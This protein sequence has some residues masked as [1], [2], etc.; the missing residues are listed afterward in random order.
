[1]TAVVPDGSI[2]KNAQDYYLLIRVG[3]SSWHE[4]T[5]IK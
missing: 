4:C 1:M 2:G 3:Q 5:S